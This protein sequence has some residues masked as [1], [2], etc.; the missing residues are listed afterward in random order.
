LITDTI[1]S[2]AVI[3]KENK[4]VCLWLGANVMVELEFGEAK[5]L[6]SVNKEN[7]ETNLKSFVYNIKLI[8][9]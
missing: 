3:G 5:S 9:G 1:F 7:A 4:C 8:L 2:K 6:L